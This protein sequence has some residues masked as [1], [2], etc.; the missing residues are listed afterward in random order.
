MNPGFRGEATVPIL[1]CFFTPLSP[2]QIERKPC[3]ADIDPKINLSPIQL[4]IVFNK[5]ALAFGPC[6]CNICATLSRF[7]LSCLL[8]C[9]LLLGALSPPLE[10]VF[11]PHIHVS[12]TF[13]VTSTQKKLP[14]PNPSWCHYRPSFSPSPP[15]PSPPFCSPRNLT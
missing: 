5:P 4:H 12:I 7:F 15:P 2:P 8:F 13:K 3:F 1:N 9:T 6:L 11:P 14:F 10:E